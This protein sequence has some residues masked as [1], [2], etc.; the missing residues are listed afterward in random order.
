MEQHPFDLH[1]D[2]EEH[3]LSEVNGIP[4]EMLGQ[5]LQSLTKALRLSDPGDLVLT[6]IFDASYA[7][8]VN[9]PKE[10]VLVQ[11]Q[12]LHEKIGKNDFSG[13]SNE[14][15]DY[16]GVL[17]VISGGRLT[18]TAEAPESEFKVT[19]G[20]IE[21]P[22]KPEFY[23]EIT[24]VQGVI[25]GIGG[26][27]LDKKSEVRISAENYGIE[28]SAKQE[29]ELVKHYKND[30]VRMTVEQKISFE[31]DTVVSASLIDF[32]ILPNTTFPERLRQFREKNPH[33]YEDIGDSV[34]AVR[35]LRDG[36]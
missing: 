26:R 6:K 25:V 30:V 36:E 7:V 13:L 5:L 2:N 31:K 14:E 16:A 10:T 22:K 28:V 1:F 24:T 17:K 18:M 11:M 34:E 33:A 35:R 21:M 12:V 29:M 19:I 27:A 32:E 4:A 23:R 8:R 15:K 9:T 20:N 3:S